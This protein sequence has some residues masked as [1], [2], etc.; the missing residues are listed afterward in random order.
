MR[1][2]AQAIV[3]DWQEA[4]QG[5]LLDKPAY[6]LA[7]ER[8][9]ARQAEREGQHWFDWT[10]AELSQFGETIGQQRLE[11]SDEDTHA[12]VRQAVAQYLERVVL[13]DRAD[14][15]IAKLVAKLRAARRTGTYM[16]NRATGKLITIVDDKASLPLL[17]PDDA[18]DE[19][20]R[21][22]R[23]YVPELAKW[24]NSGKALHYAVFTT[25][26]AEPGKLRAEM[27]GIVQRFVKIVRRSGGFP[28]VKGALL[29][30][31]APLGA[32]RDWNVHINVLLMCDGF[33]DYAKLRAAWHWDVD[34]QRV[35]ADP[36]EGESY[37]DAV[38]RSLRE[39]AKYPVQAMP[40]KSAEKRARRGREPPPAMIEWTAEEWG[41]WWDAHSRFRRTRSYG[42]LYGIPDPEPESMDGFESVG[43]FWTEGT[44]RHRRFP[45][46]DSIPGDKS[47]VEDIRERVRSAWSKLLGPPDHFEKVRE[48][49]RIIAQ[50]YGPV[51][52]AV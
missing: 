42:E 19:A 20:N 16:Y 12:N 36:R 3:N 50:H 4:T 8:E 25:P 40:T 7:A 28:E 48:A 22:Q 24:R 34:I 10:P 38:R 26:N 13:P 37:E 52:L 5:E 11:L 51:S 41:E 31:E 43:S 27:V 1:A 29:T 17:C 44:V 35:R 39:L 45:L 6:V 21:L 49:A 46:L 32:R 47:S 30:L 14:P 23:R 15:S 9:L 18:R 2:D 33:L